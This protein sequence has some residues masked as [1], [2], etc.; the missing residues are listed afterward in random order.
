MTVDADFARHGAIDDNHRGGGVGGGL[1][2]LQIKAPVGEGLHRRYQRAYVFRA[3]PGHH[4]IDGDAF[5][6]GR[7]EARLHKGDYII[8]GAAAGG[9]H[10]F[11]F[12][13]RRRTQR[14]SVTPLARDAEGVE[15]AGTSMRA[16]RAG[17][18]DALPGSAPA[19]GS[20]AMR[21]ISAT[22]VSAMARTSSRV[23]N[24]KGC[25]ITAIGCPSLPSA[26]NCLRP[27]TIN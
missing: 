9:D 22:Q 4:R 7:A 25:G 2:T 24:P 1:Y 10:A 26:F 16:A 11:D 6:C 8:G 20:T 3:A 23:R 13:E 18:L 12:V 21:A 15:L 14:Q 27:S 17:A 5:H 19:L